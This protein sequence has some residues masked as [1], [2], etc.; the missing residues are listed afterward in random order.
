MI[1]DDLPPKWEPYAQK[2]IRR[3]EREHVGENRAIHAPELMDY[4]GLS[5]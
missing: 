1:R 5:Q 3:M 2:L 4:L